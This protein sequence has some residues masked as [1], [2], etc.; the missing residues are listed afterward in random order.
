[1]SQSQQ[2]LNISEE[3]QKSVNI[4]IP[5][6]PPFKLRSS[7]IDKD[8]VIWEYLLLDYITLFKKLIALIPYNSLKNK[9]NGLVPP[10]ILTTNTLNQI[11]IFLKSFIHESSLESSHVFSLGAINPNIRENQHILKLIIFIYI[12]ETNLINLKLT[13]IS[14]W[15][16]CKVYIT[17]SDKYSC[18]KINQSLIT[19]PIIRKLIQGTI[20]SSYSSKSDDINLIR[21]LQDYLGKLIAS[22]KW[23]Q[24]DFEILYLL[25]GQRTK[26]GNNNQNNKNKNFKNIKLNNNNNSFNSEFAENFVTKHW[27]EILEELYVGGSGI[28]SKI[29]IQIM[30]ISL[31]SLSSSKILNLL[32]DQLEI[33]GIIKLKKF[34]PLVSC[35]LLSKKFN[36]LNPDLKN[37]LSTILL[38]KNKNKSSKPKILFNEENIQNVIDM[39]PQ[40]SKGQAKTLLNKNNNEVEKVI[41]YVLEMNIDNLKNIEDYDEK[42]SLKKKKK[43]QPKNEFEFHDNDKIYN[44]QIG[45][46]EINELDEINDDL[47]KKNLERAL[48][49]L[50]EP[51]EDEPDDT[52]IDNESK[53]ILITESN[54]DGENFEEIKHAK[55]ENNKLDNKLLEIESKLFGIFSTNPDKLK[56]LD[57]NTPYRQELR[58]ETGWTDE[59]IEGWA[60]IIEKQP[61][62]FRMLEERLVYVDGS[63]NKSGKKSSKWAAPSKKDNIEDNNHKT[64][65]YDNDRHATDKRKGGRLF[66]TSSTPTS[67]SSPSTPSSPSSTTTPSSKNNSNFKAYM[68]KKNKNK[69]QKPPPRDGNKGK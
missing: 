39:F 53:S 54:D 17:I 3:Y 56:R 26:K 21:S 44:V 28:Y 69:Q 4:P 48:A 16:F 6:F 60:R 33:N 12:K 15:E 32:K 37:M 34:N 30:I 7:L 8:P 27:I 62:R 47:R 68:D 43:I 61:K 22:G 5:V 31:C 40:L 1:M 42:L 14:L 51:D 35:I 52:Y 46:K 25:L 23:K 2:P 57:R 24:D 10:I 13:G 29:C 45:K 49:M 58:R 59:Q 50:Y 36:D 18:K 66:T 63:L 41:N 20:K 65:K 38:T 19:L 55:N 9:K 64:S 67:S 11:H